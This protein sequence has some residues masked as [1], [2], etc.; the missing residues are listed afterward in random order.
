MCCCNISGITGV[1]MVLGLGGDL[2][3]SQSLKELGKVG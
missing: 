3:S 2:H 1:A